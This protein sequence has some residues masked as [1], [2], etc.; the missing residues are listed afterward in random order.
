[1]I[2][3]RVESITSI[4][5]KKSRTFSTPLGRF[6]YQHVPLGSYAVGMHIEQINQHDHFLIATR[7]KALCD[8][9]ASVNNFKNQQEMLLEYTLV[10]MQAIKMENCLLVIIHNCVE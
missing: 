2:P 8:M 3:E 6:D 1:M 10:L 5:T 7:E 9:V 4:T